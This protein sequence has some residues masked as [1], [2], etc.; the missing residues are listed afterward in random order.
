M[1]V[2]LDQNRKGKTAARSSH[3]D[4]RGRLVAARWPCELQTTL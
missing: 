1:K 2:A 4:D 3:G